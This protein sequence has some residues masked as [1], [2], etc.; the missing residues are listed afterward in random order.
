M[1]WLN[2]TSKEVK[3]KPIFDIFPELSEHV[4]QEINRLYAGKSLI[5]ELKDVKLSF[6]PTLYNSSAA[7]LLL[8]SV[9]DPKWVGEF[10]EKLNSERRKEELKKVSN[11]KLKG[12]SA[13]WKMETRELNAQL[14]LGELAQLSIQET[15]TFKFLDQA[16]G[17]I[18]R[19]LD[20]ELVYIEQVALSFGNL[21]EIGEVSWEGSKN[22]IEI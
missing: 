19:R 16:V 4:L 3:G 11:T 6:F 20:L 1:H 8:A 5:R 14:L 12:L 9:K 18:S 21:D 22:Q 15:N 10:T 2:K 13:D 17:L 7:I